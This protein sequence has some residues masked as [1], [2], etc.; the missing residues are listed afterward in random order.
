MAFLD[1]IRETGLHVTSQCGGKGT[2]GKCQ[3]ILHPAP[4]PEA[5]D[6][7]HL[8]NAEIDSGYR[9]ACQH[10][11][12][13]ETRVILPT[14]EKEAKIL[15][16]GETALQEWEIDISKK[17]KLGVAIDLGTT[18]IVGYLLNLGTGV[19]L[20]QVAGLNPQVIF[21]EDVITRITLAVNED[22]GQEKLSEVVVD[23]IDVLITRLLETTN[24]K[25]EEITQISIV[26]NTAMHHLLLRADVQ[27][28]GIA[29][30]EP[31]VRSSVTK[32]A[33]EI[34]LSSVS[35]ASVYLPPNIAGFVG[36]DTVGFILAQRLELTK[37]VTLGIDIGT[38]GEI[39]LANKGELSCCSAAAGSA[40]EGANIHNGMR[41]ENGAIEYVSIIDPNSP[42]ELSVIGGETPRGICGSGIV[43]LVAELIRNGIVDS[44]GRL[45]TTSKRVFKNSE[46]EL[47]YLVSSTGESGASRNIVFT[48]KDVRQ[49][50]LAK[51]AI[52]VGSTIL[53]KESDLD[54]HDIDRVM[55]AGAFGSYIRPDSALR[56]GLFPNV[57]VERVVQVGNAAGEGAKILLLSEQSRGYVNEL[58][59]RISYLELAN[60]DDFQNVFISSLKFPR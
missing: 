34:G 16:E 19:Q 38:N 2:C 7:K 1:T 36:G 51:G 52:L 53:L 57:D 18:T 37:S 59:P 46:G 55:L 21:G 39:I 20:G 42:P 33:T 41:G 56:I 3:I 10:S 54:V 29:P 30:Y 8:S 31:S 4:E 24:H 26:G 48:Q 28:L 23:E 40:F 9:L 60:H 50:Q 13:Q 25:Q 22:G 27:P 49:V 5:A 58:I 6:L 11:V 44:S 32:T 45:L 15:Q 43:D 17:D 47:R 35:N 14:Y 12:K